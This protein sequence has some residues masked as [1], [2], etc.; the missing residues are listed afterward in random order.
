MLMCGETISNN[1]II[2]DFQ[3]KIMLNISR[4]AWFVCRRKQPS[5]PNKSINCKEETI[6]NSIASSWRDRQSAIWLSP[7]QPIHII[8]HHGGCLHL[9]SSFFLSALLRSPSPLN[10]S[11]DA[12]VEELIALVLVFVYSA[13]IVYEANVVLY[14]FNMTKQVTKWPF[15]VLSDFIFIQPAEKLFIVW[16]QFIKGRLCV[17]V[18]E[19]V[20][21]T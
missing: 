17:D 1:F 6:V 8:R 14:I 18:C 16:E 2:H 9:F 3:T 10:T 13:Y 21:V 7:I 20:H 4:A 15:Y 5:V 11:D 19:C 12:H